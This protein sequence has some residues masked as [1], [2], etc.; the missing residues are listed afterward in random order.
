MQRYHNPWRANDLLP[1]ALL[2]HLPNLEYIGRLAGGR[3]IKGRL[4]ILVAPEALADE[5]SASSKTTPT[6]KPET[7][8]QTRPGSSRASLVNDQDV[9]PTPVTALGPEPKL[10]GDVMLVAQAEPAQPRSGGGRLDG[11]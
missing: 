7:D 3:T 9:G 6:L 1:P 4:P 11:D 8:T 10:G 2:G 5:G